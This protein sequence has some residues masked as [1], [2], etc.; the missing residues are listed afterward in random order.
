MQNLLLN[1]PSI[2]LTLYPMHNIL[3]ITDKVRQ[4]LQFLTLLI[5]Y[6]PKTANFL[7][8]S[9]RLRFLHVLKKKIKM[10]CEIN[11]YRKFTEFS[12]LNIFPHITINLLLITYTYF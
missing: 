9:L 1:K 7:K 6:D 10:E 3:T 8:L 5:C 4:T 11:I 12:M 2:S